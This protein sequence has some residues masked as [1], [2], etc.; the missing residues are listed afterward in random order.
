MK[1]LCAW[2][3]LFNYSI[4]FVSFSDGAQLLDTTTTA[5]INGV[6][7][8]NDIRASSLTLLM[9]HKSMTLQQSMTFKCDVGFVS[10]LNKIK[11]VQREIVISKSGIIVTTY[12]QVNPPYEL[13]N[14]P[15]PV[16]VYILLVNL[17][18][19][20]LTQVGIELTI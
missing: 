9:S 5:F 7:D 6:F 18:Y 1:C 19:L 16:S 3:Y 14:S 8:A 17:L 20:Y 12:I 15:V 4:S 2:P 10:R 11:N 13:Y